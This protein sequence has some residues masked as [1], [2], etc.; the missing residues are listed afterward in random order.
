MLVGLA[1]YQLVSELIGSRALRAVVAFVGAQAALAYG[2][3]LWGGVKELFTTATV[4]TI[5]ALVPL[6][7]RQ[8][9]VR[10]VLPFAAASAALVAA[11]SVGGAA[12]LAL[13]LAVAA[14]LLAR[15]AGVRRAAS[16][17]RSPSSRATALFAIPAL[18]TTGTWLSRSGISTVATADEYGNLIRRLSWLQVFGIWPHGDFRTPPKSLAATYVLVALVGAG[19]VV[20]V[21]VAWRRRAWSLPV[22]LGAAVLACLVYVGERLAL[23]RREGARLGL[24][25]RPRRRPRRRRDRL[26]A[27][28]ADG[29]QPWRPLR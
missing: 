15:A 21:V 16:D 19:A 4:V 18:A 12:W 5:A 29:G 22:A 11:L 6:T 7:V 27:R 28:P 26:R 20:A 13:P 8:P 23:D 25:D 17:C 24:A 2:Y 10:A 3:A 1:L 14:F 9:R